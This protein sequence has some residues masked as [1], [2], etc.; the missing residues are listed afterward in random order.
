M[1]K[2][3]FGLVLMSLTVQAFAEDPHY[4]GSDPLLCTV[5]TTR[6]CD[7]N[8]CERIEIE[9]LGIPRHILVDFEKKVLTSTQY[10]QLNVETA[11]GSIVQIDNR[12]ILQGS[13][14]TSAEAEDA[15]AWAIVIAD[16]TGLMTFTIAGEEVA[17][18]GFGA[19]APVE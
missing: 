13:D 7:I 1:I 15:Q 19:C 16:P 3:I 10:D 9:S 12:L 2:K 18:V 6:Q 11:I 14:E 8:D 4:D 17:F 5:L